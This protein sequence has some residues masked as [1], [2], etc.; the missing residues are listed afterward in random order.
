M[1]LT[2]PSK[3]NQSDA[4]WALVGKHTLAYAGGLSVKEGSTCEN[5]TLYHG[6]LTVANV[7]SWVGTSQERNY[8]VFRADE[9]AVVLHIYT[10]DEVNKVMGNLF[11]ERLD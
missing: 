8:T 1:D 2:Y 4:E 3:P 7:P 6:P 9:G 5:G 10:R 11:W